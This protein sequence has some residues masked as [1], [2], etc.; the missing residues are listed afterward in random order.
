MATQENTRTRAD[1]A[2][3]MAYLNNGDCQHDVCSWNIWTKFKVGYNSLPFSKGKLRTVLVWII[4]QLGT[5]KCHA[6]Q[7]S[8]GEDR[9]MQYSINV[10]SIFYAVQ[11]SLVKN[12]AIQCSSIVYSKYPN[13]QYSWCAVRVYE[14]ASV[15]VGGV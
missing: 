9:A 6:V 5:S 2:Q 7:Y 11:Y 15:G 8:L 3:T 13:V 1:T 10:Y 4:I 14:P 12:T